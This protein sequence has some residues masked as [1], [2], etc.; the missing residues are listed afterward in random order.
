MERP[1]RGCA[2]EAA[3]KHREK[4]FK[5]EGKKGQN[6]AFFA[7]FLQKEGKKPQKRATQFTDSIRGHFCMM[8][9]AND[10]LNLLHQ[11]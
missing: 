6:H 5:K 7:I 3:E 2:R 10:F 1:S 11:E 9:T 8:L 4:R